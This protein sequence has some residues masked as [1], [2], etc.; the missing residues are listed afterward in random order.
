MSDRIWS[1]AQIVGACEAQV[2][3]WLP[4]EAEVE[5]R[6]ADTSQDAVSIQQP[7]SSDFC[8]GGLKVDISAAKAWDSSR[9]VADLSLPTES[10]PHLQHLLRP[11]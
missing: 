10:A 2:Q 7:V 6:Q 8:R 5:M 3:K 11:N 1:E 4:A 9:G